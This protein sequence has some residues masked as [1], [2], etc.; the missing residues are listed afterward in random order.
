MDV[1][2]H[3]EDSAGSPDT[4]SLVLDSIFYT[5]PVGIA[6][7]ENQKSYCCAETGFRAG[8]GRGLWGT[9]CIPEE[10]DSDRELLLSSPHVDS[11]RCDQLRIRYLGTE[12][13]RLEPSLVFW[14]G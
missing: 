12:L 14:L 5:K 10:A 6:Q 3:R 4:Q 8:W 13:E 1:K 2:S 7:E 9:E 11:V